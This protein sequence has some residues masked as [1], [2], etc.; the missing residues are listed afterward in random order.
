[1]TRHAMGSADAAWLHMDRPTNLMVINGVLWFDTPLDADD[2][3][4]I[5]RTRLVD[6]YPPFRR[7]VVESGIGLG[8]AQWEDDP[9]FDLDRHVHHVALPAPG[10]RAALQAFVADRMV[11]PLDRAKPLWE[12]HVIDGFGEG[13]AVLAR[14]HH[15]IADGIALA[16]VLLSLTDGEPDVGLEPPSAAERAGWL[17]RLAAATGPAGAAMS[18][19]RGA[20]DVLW[21]EGLDLLVHPAHVVDLAA[22]A[23]DDVTTAARL[24]VAPRDPDTVLKG[25][26][27]VA[28]RVAWTDPI[29]LEDVKALAHAHRATVN[30]VLVAALSGALRSY[31]VARQS[32]VEEIHAM[33]PFNLRPLD[34]PLPRELG[35]RFGLVSLPLPVGVLEPAGRLEQ[36][37]RRMAE[38][39]RSPEAP[40]A[41]ALLGAMGATPVQVET[42]LVDLFTSQG[43]LVVT[44]VPG[45]RETM[46]LAGNPVR[47]VLVWAPT[48]GG[49]GLSVAILSYAGEVVVGLVSDAGL[50]PDPERIADAFAAEVET[51]SSLP[52]GRPPPGGWA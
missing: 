31:L 8:G 20:A 1:M 2:F 30:D 28:N 15:C 21:H 34:E 46:T 9:L 43:S 17:G 24:A 18:A 41:Y 32:M 39:K 29:P 23:R 14:I 6:R 26:L 48:S 16:R 3:R 7:R 5:L 22:T 52:A 13:G 33:V 19:T 4:E 44:N 10:D 25:D 27:H 35:N 38:I 49:V 50:V 42:A 40:V 36:V 51:L 11:E 47:G 12:F 45:P 37:K